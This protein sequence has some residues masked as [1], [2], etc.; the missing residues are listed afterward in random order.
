MSTML[1]YRWFHSIWM[2]YRRDFVEFFVD[3]RMWNKYIHLDQSARTAERTRQRLV[4]AEA[5]IQR[6]EQALADKDLEAFR[7]WDEYSSVLDALTKQ[8]NEAATA[9]RVAEQTITSRVIALEAE[10][11]QVRQESAAEKAQLSNKIK[12]LEA[13]NA[14][15]EKKLQKQHDL[16]D[17]KV[18]EHPKGYDTKSAYKFAS[19][20]DLLA[21]SN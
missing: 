19:I 12:Q 6:L 4:Q 15:L 7:A 9:R 13:Q 2:P 10:L 14:I 17:K 5:D 18:K 8:V 16:L 21:K 11:R 3:C 1:T 20:D